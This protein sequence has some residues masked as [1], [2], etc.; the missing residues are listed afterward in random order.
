[1]FKR[2]RVEISWGRDHHHIANVTAFDEEQALFIALLEM[3]FFCQD[4]EL[5]PAEI[6][7]KHAHEWVLIACDPIS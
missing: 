1:M 3:V 6:A 4:E 7:R 5:F 2:Y